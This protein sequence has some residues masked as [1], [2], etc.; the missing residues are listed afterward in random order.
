M[1]F[2]RLGF[3]G[4]ISAR[5]SR[6]KPKETEMTEISSKLAK[7]AMVGALILAPMSLAGCGAAVGGVAGG[8]AGNQIG[9]GNGKTAATIGGAVA[10]A[11]IG[12]E[13]SGGR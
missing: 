5:L 1:G 8:V 9:S 2:L 7:F 10:G 4:F 12:N 3:G 6:T 13:V 11:V